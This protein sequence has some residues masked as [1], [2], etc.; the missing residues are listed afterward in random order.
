MNMNRQINW[1]PSC[2]V[3]NFIR[4]GTS[5]QIVIDKQARGKGGGGVGVW[6]ERGKGSEV[7]MVV[8]EGGEKNT[9]VT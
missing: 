2:R 8:H 3:L 4:I 9:H 7:K 1:N 5:A 6:G